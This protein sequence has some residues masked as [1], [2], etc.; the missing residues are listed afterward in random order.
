MRL[1]KH[2]HAELVKLWLEGQSLDNYEICFKG[3]V[4]RSASGF[5]T[6]TWGQ[7]KNLSEA[8]TDWITADPDSYKIQKAD[9]FLK[10][11]AKFTA[12]CKEKTVSK[13]TPVEQTML[14]YLRKDYPNI[15]TAQQAIEAAIDTDKKLQSLNPFNRQ[16]WA[17]IAQ[18]Q[19]LYNLAKLLEKEEQQ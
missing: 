8:D 19:D 1:K 3:I 18:T 9:K 12:D 17:Y 5:E 2:P 6:F 13:L 7:W 16:Q 14:D 4:S 15:T 10:N 11:V